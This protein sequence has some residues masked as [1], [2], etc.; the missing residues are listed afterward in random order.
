MCAK[1]QF[2]F[3]SMSAGYTRVQL[4]SYT[5]GDEF[6]VRCELDQGLRQKQWAFFC[7]ACIRDPDV[8][9]WLSY[10]FEFNKAFHTGLFRYDAYYE[11]ESRVAESKHQ[12]DCVC[13]LC[14]AYKTKTFH[15]QCMCTMLDDKRRKLGIVELAADGDTFQHWSLCPELDDERPRS[16]MD[17]S[18][19]DLRESSGGWRDRNV[20]LACEP[21]FQKWLFMRKL[22]P[23][24]VEVNDVP[25]SRTPRVHALFA[26]RIFGN[27]ARWPSYVRVRFPREVQ[28]HPL[29]YLCAPGAPMT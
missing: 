19:F 29:N 4:L 3:N 27:P 18:W 28:S 6:L 9:H 14:T 22:I 17:E 16:W 7:S 26:H 5:E 10:E 20:P 1:C 12:G 8:R 21:T 24:Y 13:K 23:A 25:L 2:A 11:L 15:R